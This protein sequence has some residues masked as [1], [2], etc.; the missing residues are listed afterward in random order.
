[1]V[2]YPLVC[3]GFYTPDT[4]GSRQ[5]TERRG[6]RKQGQ[7]VSQRCHGCVPL[8]GRGWG[9]VAEKPIKGCVGQIRRCVPRPQNW[10][11]AGLW[12]GASPHHPPLQRIPALSGLPNLT[13]Y[14]KWKSPCPS[15]PYNPALKNILLGLNKNITQNLCQVSVFPV[16]LSLLP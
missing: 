10:R 1:M 6:L 16:S 9:R 15:C 11:K 8:W 14:A 4:P 3:I 5:R 12:H 2:P 7:P 13:L